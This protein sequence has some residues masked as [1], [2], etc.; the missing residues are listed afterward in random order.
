[1]LNRCVSMIRLWKLY[2]FTS[3]EQLSDRSCVASKSL[4]LCALPADETVVQFPVDSEREASVYQFSS[5]SI[6]EVKHCLS[7][8]TVLLVHQT[9]FWND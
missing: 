4:I 6:S 2:M 1:M 9:A 5:T 7:P 8:T 3:F